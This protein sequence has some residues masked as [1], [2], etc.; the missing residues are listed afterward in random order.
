MRPCPHIRILSAVATL[1]FGFA[2]RSA[3]A[4][5]A[6]TVVT[7]VRPVSPV[8]LAISEVRDDGYVTL[9]DES[10][11]EP[12]LEDRPTTVTWRLDDFVEV[13]RIPA[14]RGS[15]EFWLI[16]ATR[17]DTAAARFAGRPHETGPRLDEETGEEPAD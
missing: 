4:Q 16:N 15:Y 14:P 5:E 1:A 10:F 17:A 9:A 8:G 7:V 11:W 12:A 13:R 6:A 3:A 2:A